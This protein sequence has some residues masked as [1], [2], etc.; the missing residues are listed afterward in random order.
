MKVDRSKAEKALKKKGFRR[1]SS[2]SHIYYL[3]YYNDLETGIKT[4]FSHS[5]KQRDISGG[6]LEAMKKEL[7]LDK[8][9]DIYDLLRCPMDGAMY[10]EILRK[11]GLLDDSC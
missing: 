7:Q 5:P 6:L 4:C 1:D 2:P 3:H 9:K 8:T 10:N 11:K